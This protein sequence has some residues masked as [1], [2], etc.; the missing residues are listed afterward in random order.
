MAVF[1]KEIH[2]EMVRNIMKDVRPERV[3]RLGVNFTIEQTNIDSLIGRTAHILF[4]ENH[5]LIQTFLHTHPDL[6]S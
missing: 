3:H 4:L 2:C 6:L 1:R 5:E